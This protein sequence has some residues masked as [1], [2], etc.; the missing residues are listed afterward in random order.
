MTIKKFLGIVF[1]YLSHL[2]P[3][4]GSQNIENP[5]LGSQHIEDPDL[6]SQN[7]EDPDLGSQN[8]EDPDLWS[9][10]IE[11]PDLGCQTVEDLKP[12]CIISYKI[13]PLPP[14]FENLLFFQKIGYFLG[15][16]WLNR[17]KY[18]IFRGK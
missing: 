1:L 8:I 17:G 18:M 16:Y 5:D 2:D 13:I 3:D 14:T 6:G 12:G 10:N 7:I 9:Q 15:F 4:L 11:D